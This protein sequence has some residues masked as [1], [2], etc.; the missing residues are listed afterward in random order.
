MI[1]T[2]VLPPEE[3]YR[4]AEDLPESPLAQVDFA[5]LNGVVCVAEAHGP[6]PPVIIGAWCLILT[7]HAEPVYIHPDYR[8]RGLEQ[9]TV[10][11]HLYAQLQAT[12]SA[13]NV[14]QALAIVEDP[15]LQQVVERMGF[16]PV[17]GALYYAT[18]PAP[19]SEDS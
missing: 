17:P 7:W 8:R 2:R 18:A 1:T 4:I 13:A 9:S 12:M 11:H 14:Q 3:Y 5:Q 6:A 16:T 15:A 10:A 19:P